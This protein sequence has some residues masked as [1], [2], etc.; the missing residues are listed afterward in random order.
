M[1][2]QRPGCCQQIGRAGIG[3]NF[4]F[5]PRLMISEATAGQMLK[6]QLTLVHR[7]IAPEL[8]TRIGIKLVRC[9]QEQP[10]AVLERGNLECGSTGSPGSPRTSPV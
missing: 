8:G 6:G 4:R 5:R 1:H 10:V 3:G 9:A 7:I 2:P